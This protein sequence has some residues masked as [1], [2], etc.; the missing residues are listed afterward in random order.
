MRFYRATASIADR[1]TLVWNRRSNGCFTAGCGVP[2][3]LTLS[4]LDL[5]QYDGAQSLKASSTSSIDNVEQVRSPAA[6]A[7]VYKVKDE[8]T[9]VDG[10]SAEPFALAATSQI[11]PVAAPR[12]TVALSLNR[13]SARQ[14]EPVTVTAT[15]TNSSPDMTGDNAEVTLDLPVGVELT[16]GSPTWQAGTLAPSAAPTHQWTVKGSTDAVHELTATAEDQAYQETFTS[17]PTSAALHVDSRPPVVQVACPGA[18]NTD[19]ALTVRWGAADASPIA[20]YDVDVAVDGGASSPWL[21]STSGTSATYA[22]LP[23]HSYSFSVRATDG[24]G[25]SSGPVSCGWATI[26][27]ASPPAPSPPTVGRPLPSSA[28]LRLSRI[29]VGRTALTASGTLARD[30]TGVVRASYSARGSMVR[31]KA[32]V[33]H[34]RYRLTF[35]LP[36][37]LRR[38]ARGVLRISYGGDSRHAA[39]RVSRHVRR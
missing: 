26:V 12:P 31:A 39:Q 33:S 38:A 36:R 14:G 29:S 23:G 6:G 20:G 32:A 25:N 1:A 37:A 30:A 15:L 11:T 2:H 10:L 7:T 13:T 22:G 8:S 4:N 34:G 28:R 16:S 5:F 21:R 27:A 9:T 17:P 35:H 18:A 19:P 3:G 24:L